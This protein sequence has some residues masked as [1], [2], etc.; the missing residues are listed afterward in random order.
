[1]DILFYFVFPIVTIIFAIALE[2]VLKSPITTTLVIFAIFLVLTFTAYTEVFLI[3]TIIYTIIAF[4]TAV[5]T[6]I[7]LRRKRRFC[8]LICNNESENVNSLTEEEIN[9]IARQ[10][11]QI[12][13]NQ[14][15]SCCCR[16]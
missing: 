6:N 2:K 3:N 5:L 7:F 16:R 15:T 11:A 12:L 8:N 13:N 4:I 14:M 9:R 1:M 10:T